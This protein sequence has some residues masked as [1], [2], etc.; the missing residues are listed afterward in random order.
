MDFQ[1]CFQKVI[2]VGGGQFFCPALN[3]ISMDFL[4][5]LI[6]NSMNLFLALERDFQRKLFISKTKLL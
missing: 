3:T 5:A 4:V 2:M 6:T 1:L